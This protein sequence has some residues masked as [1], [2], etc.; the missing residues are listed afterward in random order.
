[1]DRRVQVTFDAADPHKLARWW[2]ELLHYQIVD[3]HDLVTRLL[4]D[5][6]VAETE[7]VRIDGRLFWPMPLQPPIRW[8]EAHGS[9]SS[10]SRSP[11]RLRT[12]YISTWR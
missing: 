6:A 9:S 5:G 1:M 7:V 8:A 12:A 10:E 2:A 4:A 11:S 3:A